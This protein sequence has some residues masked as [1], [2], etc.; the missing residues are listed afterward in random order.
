MAFTVGATGAGNVLNYEYSTTSDD[1]YR[2]G[3]SWKGRQFTAIGSIQVGT[4]DA[5]LN[6]TIIDIGGSSQF[7]AFTI[8]GSALITRVE[9]LS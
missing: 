9:S 7:D 8:A 1:E 3:G 6:F 2:N 4:I 5:S